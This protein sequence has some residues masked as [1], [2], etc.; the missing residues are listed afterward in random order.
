MPNPWNWKTMRAKHAVAT[1]A[2]EPDALFESRWTNVRGA[3][4]HS[5]ESRHPPLGVTP[6][7]LVHGLAV[8]HRYLMP[9]GALLSTGR[10]VRAVDLPGFGLSEGARETLDVP[11]LADRLADWLKASGNAPADLLGNSVGAQVAVDA[12]ARYPELV[13]K[14]VLV[15]PTMDPRARSMTRQAL[16]WLRGLPRENPGLLPILLRDLADAGLVR[17][18]R[19]FREA[20][21]DPVERKLPSVLAPALVTRG[22]HEAVASQRWAEEVARLLPHGELAVVPDSPHDATFTTAHGLAAI[23][24]PF[25]DR[26]PA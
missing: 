24:V 25:L 20:L 11:A 17:A 12:A 13:R 14:L 1:R 22:E 2:P 21:R 10:P 9:L 7:V 23:T 15:G 19:T 4:L 3:Q 6:L 18:V 8:S 5:R 16:R 26:D